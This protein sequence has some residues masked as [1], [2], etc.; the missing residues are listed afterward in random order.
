M[1]T[2]ALLTNTSSTGLQQAL[3]SFLFNQPTKSADSTIYNTKRSLQR[4]PLRA[5]F[6]VINPVYNLRLFLQTQLQTLNF[7]WSKSLS[8]FLVCLNSLW[9]LP[10]MGFFSP[11]FWFSIW[12]MYPFRH[13]QFQAQQVEQIFLS[14]PTRPLFKFPS[15]PTRPSTHET[16][17]LFYLS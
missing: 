12:R 11:P 1:T 4:S 6:P 7:L 2:K 17:T 14:L 15:K 10:E 13:R 9:F 8:N 3:R 5:Q 16:V